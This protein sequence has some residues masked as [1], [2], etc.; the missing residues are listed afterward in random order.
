M[1]KYSDKELQNKSVKELQS[2]KN[3]LQQSKGRTTPNQSKQQ[4]EPIR[5]I[6]GDSVLPTPSTGRQCPASEAYW[7]PDAS[8][9]GNWIGTP[10]CI[11]W[12]NNGDGTHRLSMENTIPIA[13][14]QITINQT[15]AEDG[16]QDNSG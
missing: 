8:A 13:G 10:L 5:R 11:E 7:D 6:Q 9:D 16:I 2:I 14:V 4:S 3:Q 1:A 12:H 15:I